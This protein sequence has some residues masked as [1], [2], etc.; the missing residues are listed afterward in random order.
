MVLTNGWQV[1]L[2]SYL[3]LGGVGSREGTDKTDAERMGSPAP[4]RQAL[5]CTLPTNKSNKM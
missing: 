1:A 4:L 5:V 3:S 2:R